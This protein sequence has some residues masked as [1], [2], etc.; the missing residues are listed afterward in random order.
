MKGLTETKKNTVFQFTSA[1]PK[2]Y[3]RETKVTKNGEQRQTEN[4]FL[5]YRT[6]VCTHK[7]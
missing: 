4:K 2:I 1:K 7:H 6:Q 3:L 5:P